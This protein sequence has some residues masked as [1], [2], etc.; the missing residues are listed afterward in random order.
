MEDVYI[1]AWT[2]L[3]P[4]TSVASWFRNRNLFCY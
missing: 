4:F 2:K 3:L 1:Q